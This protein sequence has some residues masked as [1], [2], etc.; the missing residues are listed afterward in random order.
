MTGRPMRATG[1][2]GLPPHGMLL[3]V[4]AAVLSALVVIPWAVSAVG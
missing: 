1:Q 3:R 4:L 2:E